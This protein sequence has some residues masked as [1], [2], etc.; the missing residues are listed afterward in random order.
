MAETPKYT[1]EDK[2]HWEAK[3]LEAEAADLLRHPVLK[4]GFWFSAIPALAAVL[5]I[6]LQYYASALD[7]KKAELLREEAEFKITQAK[8]QLEDVQREVKTKQ[9]ELDNL[10]EVTRKLD[11]VRAAKD[12]EIAAINDAIKKLKDEKADHRA[13]IASLDSS[14][15]KLQG[16]QSLDKSLAK[17]Q[18]NVMGKLS[19][20]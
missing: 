13:A 6:G 1:D 5:G 19:R 10:T 2:I 7:Y 15:L 4:P 3:K 14:L 16:H 17:E 12:K 11:E 8:Q 9:T 20:K 18:F